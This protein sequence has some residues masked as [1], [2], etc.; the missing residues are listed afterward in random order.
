MSWSSEGA[1]WLTLQQ[2]LVAPVSQPSE[3][4]ILHRRTNECN[5]DSSEHEPSIGDG[6]TSSLRSGCSSLLRNGVPSRFCGCSAL[7]VEHAQ[8]VAGSRRPARR[9]SHRFTNRHS[10]R[11]WALL[12]QPRLLCHGVE[13]WMRRLQG[14]ALCL[15]WHE[16]PLACVSKSGRNL[17]SSM[18]LSLSVISILEGL[19]ESTHEPKFGLDLEGQTLSFL[20]IFTR[21]AFHVVPSHPMHLTLP[22]SPRGLLSWYERGLSLNHQMKVSAL[23]SNSPHKSRSWADMLRMWSRASVFE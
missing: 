11:D 15:S 7:V 23:L 12:S 2:G 3:L 10:I 21:Y 17:T 18:F 6:L 5:F 13:C 9:Q 22:E 19:P 4:L 14:K 16:W 1:V 8:A 20:N